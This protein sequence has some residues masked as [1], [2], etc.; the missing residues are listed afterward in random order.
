MLLVAFRVVAEFQQ[1]DINLGIPYFPSKPRPVLGDRIREQGNP[2]WAC[3]DKV[4]LL[5]LQT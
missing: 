3:C 2:H 4:I 5:P 1:E